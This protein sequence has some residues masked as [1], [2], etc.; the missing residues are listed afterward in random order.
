VDCSF[1]STR[2]GKEKK[3]EKKRKKERKKERKKKKKD[4]N[5]VVFR[6]WRLYVP[7]TRV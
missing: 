1:G 2:L 6:R 3:K 5:N 4:H 7:R